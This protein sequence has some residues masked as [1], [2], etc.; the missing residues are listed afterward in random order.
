MGQTSGKIQA[1]RTKFRTNTQAKFRA[2]SRGVSGQISG[3]SSGQISERKFREEQKQTKNVVKKANGPVTDR[4]PQKNMTTKLSCP[5]LDSLG[6]VSVRGWV[7][8][9]FENHVGFFSPLHQCV[10]VAHVCPR[11]SSWP[12]F[13]SI[14][15][16][17]LHEKL[18]DRC[19]VSNLE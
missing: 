7:L 3:E 16:A 6:F 9:M 4:T 2:N 19:A 12:P 17:V 1:N 8:D 11:N 10:T 5:N 18:A 14:V 13:L 15:P